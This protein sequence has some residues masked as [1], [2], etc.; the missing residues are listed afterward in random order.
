MKPL[1]DTKREKSYNDSS[2]S[3]NSQFITLSID[4]NQSK[5]SNLASDEQLHKL[6]WYK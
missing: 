1:H 5:Y 4:H 2:W 3:R 6:G